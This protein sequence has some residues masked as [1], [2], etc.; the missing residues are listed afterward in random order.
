MREGSREGGRERGEGA[1]EWRKEGGREGEGEGIN[2]G[3]TREMRVGCILGKE[4]GVTVYSEQD[5]RKEICIAW[6]G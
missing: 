6:F 2:G 5:N 4:G 1:W 3:R